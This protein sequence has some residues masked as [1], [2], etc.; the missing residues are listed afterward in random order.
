M[1]KRPFAS[2]PQRR[3]IRGPLS[4]RGNRRLAPSSK[5]LDRLDSA[6]AQVV[7]QLNHFWYIEP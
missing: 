3:L 6:N 5:A 1:K 7:A 2:P 4:L